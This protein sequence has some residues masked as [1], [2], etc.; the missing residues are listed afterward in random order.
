MLQHNFLGQDLLGRKRKNCKGRSYDLFLVLLR[1]HSTKEN[2]CFKV[3]L[4][5]EYLKKYLFMRLPVQEGG[6]LNCL[7]VLA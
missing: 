7:L 5:E 6:R 1:R 2:Y 4:S 3:L